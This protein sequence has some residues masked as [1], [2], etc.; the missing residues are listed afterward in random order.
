VH[1]LENSL[2]R[3]LNAGCFGAAI[4]YRVIEKALDWLNARSFAAP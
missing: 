2:V 3:G 4:A 1:Q